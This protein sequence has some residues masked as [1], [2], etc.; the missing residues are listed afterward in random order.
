MLSGH[1]TYSCWR[2]VS[3]RF[4]L[5]A[6]RFTLRAAHPALLLLLHVQLRPLLLVWCSA[7]SSLKLVVLVFGRGAGSSLLQCVLVFFR[8]VCSTL[9]VLFHYSLLCCALSS[10]LTCLSLMGG[11]RS[12]L[13]V[14]FIFMN[15]AQLDALMSLWNVDELGKINE[16]VSDLL[17][18]VLLVYSV[19]ST[20][21]LLCALS[22]CFS[23]F[24][25]RLLSHRVSIEFPLA[26]DGHPSIVGMVSPIDRCGHCPFYSFGV[27]PFYMYSFV[28]V[29]SLLLCAFFVCCCALS[30]FVA[31][32]SLLL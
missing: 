12:T 20:P 32:R 5:R 1:W 14:L 4:T 15:P 23:L 25:S 16:W 13:L 26:I 29:R 30:L 21:L 17:W 22:S 10:S 18:W 3:F 6:A 11:V 28:A 19:R 31:V 7:F 8:A 27:V 24:L 9:L 2:F